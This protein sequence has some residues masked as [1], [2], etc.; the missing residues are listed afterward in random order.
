MY[1]LKKS[2]RPMTIRVVKGSSRSMLEK[3]E[4]KVGTAK[5]MM[6]KM[7]PTATINRKVG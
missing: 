4:A 6:T 7:T 5:V 3:V 1:L 2:E